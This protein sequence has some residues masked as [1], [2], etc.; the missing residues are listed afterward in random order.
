MYSLIPFSAQVYP[1]GGCRHSHFTDEN[2]HA[3]GG[4]GTTCGSALNTVGVGQTLLELAVVRE[5]TA[6][7]WTDHGLEISERKRRVD[8]YEAVENLDK[9]PLP[10]STAPTFCYQNGACEESQTV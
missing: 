10:S 8:V 7:I 9:T 5:K 2:A 6:W 4:L 1:A 3:L